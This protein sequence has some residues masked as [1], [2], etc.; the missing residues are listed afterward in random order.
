MPRRRRA[1]AGG[2]HELAEEITVPSV[3]GLCLLRRQLVTD[4]ALGVADD[5]RPARP[6]V[7]VQAVTVHSPPPSASALCQ[8][9]T[10]A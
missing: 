3:E 7:A 5:E 10:W 8:A 4:L 2:W 1:T 6:D 9:I